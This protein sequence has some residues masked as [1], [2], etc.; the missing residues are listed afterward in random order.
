M[1]RIGAPF[2]LILLC[3]AATAQEMTPGVDDKCDGPVYKWSEVSRKAVVKH[4]PDPGFTEEARRNGVSGVVRL[5]AV[6]CKTGRVTDIQ[7]VQGLPDGLTE[8]AV[9]SARATVFTPAEKDGQPASTFIKFEYGFNT[10]GSGEECKPGECVGRLVEELVVEG[11]RRLTDEEIIRHLKTRPGEPYSVE[12]IQ[13]DLQALLNLSVFDTTQTRV[14][15]EEGPRGGVRVI[16]Y[17]VE[18]PIIRDLTFSGMHVIGEEDVL[19]AWREAGVRVCKECPY[20]PSQVTA[21]KAVVRRML[22]ERGE[23][24]VTIEVT[25]S[26]ISTVS[27]S[28]DFAITKGRRFD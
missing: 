6:L 11:N 26:E 23:A 3:A 27:V 25:I 28:L 1:K 8:A 19:K 12:Q 5:T 10:F 7:V 21:A 24:D 14:A 9:S 16:F 13:R 18:R 17:V 22:Q 4:K 15:T 2:V 20:D